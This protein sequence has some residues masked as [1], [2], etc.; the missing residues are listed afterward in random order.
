[1]NKR[2]LLLLFT[3]AISLSS[4]L[5][6]QSVRLVTQADVDAFDPATTTIAGELIIGKEMLTGG[7]SDITDLSNL[8]NLQTI[9]ESMTIGYT[10]F[11]ED[12]SPLANISKIGE[13][14]YLLHNLALEKIDYFADLERIEGSF[15]LW[16]NPVLKGLDGFDKLI[17]VG[18]NFTVSSCNALANLNGFNFLNEVVNDFKIINNLILTT[19]D[20][21]N[22][23]AEIGR[24]C[25]IN[26]ND[27]LQSI[28]GINKLTKVGRNLDLIG[29]LVLVNLDNLITLTEL[30]GHLKISRN[31]QLKHIDGFLNLNSI[32]GYLDI[33][34]NTLLVHLNGLRNVKS[35]G[36]Y[37]NIQENPELISLDGLQKLE[38]IGFGI[39]L[40]SNPQLESIGA[41]FRLRA[42]NGSLELSS[43]QVLSNLDGIKN[44]SRIDGDLTIE[45]NGINHINGLAKLTTVSGSVH[46]NDCNL[47]TNLDSLANLSSVG[48][49]LR[50]VFNN[51]L[52]NCCGIVSLIDSESAV[53]GTIELFG[54]P[55]ECSSQMEVITSCRLNIILE[56]N[57]PCFGQ[58][59]G[60]FNITIRDHFDTDFNYF[61]FRQEDGTTGSG[62][63]NDF[64]FTIGVLGAGTYDLTIT[65]TVMDTA[66]VRDVTLGEVDGSI[67]E[68]V[69]LETINSTNQSA[70]GSILI[71]VAGGNP[72][73]TYSW[74]G[75]I[76]GSNNSVL[77]DTFELITLHSGTYNIEV[78]SSDGQLKNVEFEILDEDFPVFPCTRPMDIIFLNDISGSVDDLEYDQSKT[79]Y[80]D[81]VHA[82]NVGSGELESRVALAEWSDEGLLAVPI[83]DSKT[84]FENYLDWERPFDG[85]TRPINALYTGRNYLDQ[86][87]RE[88]VAKVI[89]LSTDA[90]PG[91]VSPALIDYAQNL[92]SEGFI[93]VTIAFD[94]AFST[95]EVRTILTRCSSSS[96]LAPGAL[97]YHALNQNL[98]EDIVDKFF[99]PID[100]GT[101]AST[102]FYKDGAI[103]LRKLIPVDSC[104]NPT[105]YEVE[106]SVA[107]LGNLSLPAG[108]P[109]TFYHNNPLNN[110]ATPILT[111]RIPC[112]ISA[113]EVDTFAVSL[114][115]TFIS[116]IYVMLND[117]GS[118]I[119]PS[120]FPITGIKE[121]NYSNNIDSMRPETCFDDRPVLQAFKYTTTPNPI[122][123]SLVI[124]TIDVCNISEYDAK[125]V[126]VLDRPP[127]YFV[128]ED[129]DIIDNGCSTDKGDFLFD[130]PSGCCVSITLY[131]NSENSRQGSYIVQNVDIRGP[132]NQHYISFDGSLYTT[133]DVVINGENDCPSTNIELIKSVSPLT[134]C[135]DRS[136]VYEFTIINETNIPLQGLQFKDIL[137][138]PV[139]WTYQPYLL[140]NIS[141]S[142]LSIS[143]Q[144][145]TFLINRV[146][147]NSIATFYMDAYMGDWME[148]GTLVNSASLSSV[149]DLENGGF[150]ELTSNQVFTQVSTGNEWNIADT[151]YV[152]RG[153]TNVILNAQV[154]TGTDVFWSS[155]GDGYFLAPDSTITDYVFG[156]L[157][158]ISGF[159]DIN[160]Y[161]NSD[162]G[163]EKNILILIEEGC[164]LDVIQSKAGPCQDNGTV[165]TAS[166]DY[167]NYY[168]SVDSSG[169]GE[170]QNYFLRTNDTTYGPYNYLEENSIQ[171]DSDGTSIKLTFY[172]EENRNCVKIFRV[173]SPSCSGANLLDSNL[174]FVPNIF[175]PNG[176]KINDVFTVY[177]GPYVE[178]ILLF[179]IYD[180]WGSIVFEVGPYE[181]DINLAENFGWDG[182]LRGKELNHSGFVYQLVFRL[183]DDQI[184]NRTGDLT[185][186][187]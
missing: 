174:I 176:D 130:I 109:I 165:T 67:F 106:F 101:Q 16:N 110:G 119:P 85:G 126:K 88:N 46:M 83:T 169:V 171:F 59:N 43:N 113:G 118:R 164:V 120:S 1:M 162:C 100:P 150:L 9:E 116:H 55:S 6:A 45:K 64:Y 56:K 183:V 77:V 155:D 92:I 66:Y 108:M 122:C 13:D 128:L 124:Y 99:C 36:G 32:V 179:R 89:V 20:G 10:E 3:I 139:N 170:S 12:L 82:L 76:S 97:T 93:I 87:A 75:P 39:S 167:F 111:F 161:E 70:N 146:E 61:W 175:T 33:S 151:I 178:E 7:Y 60:A 63:V 65:N 114:P 112:A 121:L 117:N 147:P 182:K 137:P 156:E 153:Q 136:I 134:S 11:L 14:F 180:R 74:T 53:G 160:I 29:N 132:L 90:N 123:N 68:I 138:D 44:V 23:L 41:L 140:S 22:Q 157:D 159:V 5:M 185:L 52:I 148:S 103:D 18:D 141:I 72:P 166:D 79:F 58:H 115:F 95:P 19:I 133:E 152:D 80:V 143:D 50:L 30:G 34:G 149:P 125:D 94:E 73:Y 35:I 172:D 184:L 26:F 131:Y 38:Q 144:E 135:E 57:E 28:N 142:R 40:G 186:W 91:Q 48:N 84:E 15:T 27:Q 47:V 2:W 17:V 54:N 105:N 24:N 173:S 96:S 129:F 25:H 8:S 4:Q 42:I 69:E 49:D 31:E 145:A 86:V 78:R 21:F 163:Q 104:D 102:F 177:P 127:E 158:L 168:F 181:A 98:A 187:K 37:L 51:Q 62:T 154:A 81:L 71:R 107:A